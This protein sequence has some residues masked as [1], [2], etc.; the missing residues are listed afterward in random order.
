[1]KDIDLQKQG[2]QHTDDKVRSATVCR[3]DPLLHIWGDKVEV[4]HVFHACHLRTVMEAQY[5][6]GFPNV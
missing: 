4:W 2:T 3:S 1:M 5:L 6:V